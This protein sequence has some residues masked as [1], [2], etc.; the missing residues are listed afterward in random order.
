VIHTDRLDHIAAHGTGRLPR[1]IR[2]TDD[3]V[4]SVHAGY[5]A[6]CTP[7][8]RDRMVHEGGMGTAPADYPG[9]YAALEVFLVEPLAVS[10]D[11]AQYS[12]DEDPT[13][14]LFAAVPVDLV[15]ALV[16][17]HGGEHIAQDSGDDVMK[18]LAEG[19]AG[20]VLGWSAL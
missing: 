18:A 17:E 13:V 2:F 3:A 10:A 16:V 14:G 11:W 7:R 15:R 19:M 20:D 5:G 1:R 6:Y 12:A 4:I 9:P 8:P